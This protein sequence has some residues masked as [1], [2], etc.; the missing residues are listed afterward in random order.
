MGGFIERITSEFKIEAE[1][2]KQGGPGRY[3]KPRVGY[4]GHLHAMCCEFKEY[5]AQ[6]PEFCAALSNVDGWEEIVVQAIDTTSKTVSEQLGG[7]VPFSDRGLASSG[8]I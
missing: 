2:M 7:G 3:K 1:T 5:S 6:S 4:M 8:S